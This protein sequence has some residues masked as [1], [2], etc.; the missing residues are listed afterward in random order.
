VKPYLA[1]FNVEASYAAKYPFKQGEIVLVAGR[2]LEHARPHGHCPLRRL[3]IVGLAQRELPKVEGFRNMKIQAYLPC[4]N[5]ADVLPHTL[6]HLHEQGCAVHILEGWSNDGS[7]EIAQ[8]QA[9]SC[10]RFPADGPDTIQ[11][12]TAILERIEHLAE[13]SDADWILYS[14]ADEWRRAPAFDGQSPTFAKAWDDTL[15]DAVRVIDQRGFNAIDFRVF[16]FYAVGDMWNRQ[17]HDGKVSPEQFFRYFDETD[18]ISRIPN[19][20]LWKNVGRVQLTGGGHEVQFP[21]MRVYPL[22]FTMK[23]YPFR[24]PA[25]AKAK[26]ETRLARRNHQE[27]A[28]GWG[29]HYDQ[30]P[31]GFDFCWDPAKLL[32][33]KDTRSPLP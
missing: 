1:K 13:A 7:W 20:K 3:C 10:E 28:Q 22:K 27:H 8:Q 16:Q 26:I 11:N 25:Q 31:P 19:R 17:E 30:Y 14:D 33:W 23:H 12:C 24:T 5:E 21:G 4:F 6:R 32:Y 18:C 9:D 29:V 2:S 15:N